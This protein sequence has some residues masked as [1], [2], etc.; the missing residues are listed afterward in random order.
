MDKHGCVMV[1]PLFSI[2]FLPR[3][4]TLFMIVKLVFQSG[5][6][7]MTKTNVQTDVLDEVFQV[8]NAN[9]MEKSA[10]TVVKRIKFHV[11]TFTLQLAQIRGCTSTASLAP[12]LEFQ[13][14]REGRTINQ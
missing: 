2:S 8:H 7:L 1:Q 11:I 9:D 13:Q 4:W 10:S 12:G 6:V 3:S 5:T 14:H